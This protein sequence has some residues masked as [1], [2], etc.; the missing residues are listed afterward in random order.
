MSNVILYVF[1]IDLVGSLALAF[2][3]I[4]VLTA[5]AGF[6]I[7]VSDDKNKFNKTRLW[8]IAGGLGLALAMAAVPAKS[9][10]DKMLALSVVDNITQ[11]LASIEGAEALPANTIKALNGFLAQYAPKPE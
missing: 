8:M 6:G 3:A 1:L 2:G 11:S 10:F 4:G 5:A 7:S 9:T